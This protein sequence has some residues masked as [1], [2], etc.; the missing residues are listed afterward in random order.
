MHMRAKTIA[1]QLFYPFEKE[2]AEEHG[3]SDVKAYEKWKEDKMRRDND[4]MGVF[5]GPGDQE[6]I[7][8][9]VE[10]YY[11][12]LEL[13]PEERSDIDAVDTALVNYGY[14]F[15]TNNITAATGSWQTANGF[16]LQIWSTT[17]KTSSKS[18][19]KN[20]DSQPTTTKLIV[21]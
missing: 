18:P 9:W 20:V 13:H 21:K 1:D 5:V 10:N 12:E 7:T 15:A 14:D 16:T 17:K 2:E 3:F 19:T 6:L 11:H 4:F 8:D